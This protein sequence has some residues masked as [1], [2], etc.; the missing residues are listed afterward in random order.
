MEYNYVTP[1]ESGVFLCVKL[2]TYENLGGRFMDNRVSITDDLFNVFNYAFVETAPYSFFIPTREKYVAVNLPKKVYNCLACGNTLEVQYNQNGVVY[3][4][5][6][7]FE[8]QRLMYE[9]RGLEFPD[10]KA[11][12]AEEPFVYQAEGYCECCGQRILAIDDRKQMISNLCLEIHRRDE[13]ILE[14]ARKIMGNCVKDW[15]ATIQESSQLSQYDLSSYTSL[16]NLLCAVILENQSELKNCAEIY[17]TV[18]IDQITKVQNLL[19]SVGEKWEAYAIRP[20]SIYESMSDE[21]YHEYT[22]VFP[23]KETVNQYFYVNK[24]IEKKRVKMF[25]DQ[26]RIQ[27][28]EELI[29][30]AGFLDIW[31]DWLIDHV[32]ALKK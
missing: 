21:L 27:T 30:E 4:S 29:C 5:K 6:E 11:I 13:K 8:E 20:T 32:T 24:S 10:K 12:K 7:R 9:K 15:L 28:V 31:V 22:V 25:L 23:V 19:D 3:F 2:I 14:D 17:R 18:M 1:E 26:R 16:Q